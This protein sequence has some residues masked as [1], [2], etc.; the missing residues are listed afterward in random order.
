MAVMVFCLAAAF[1]LP[2]LDCRPMHADE[3][4]LAGKFGTPLETGAYPYDPDEYHGLVLAYLDW[5][6]AHLTGRTSYARLRETTLR[7]APALAGIAGIARR[8][9]PP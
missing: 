2:L 5:I 8:Y 9:R 7:I 1:R 3:A 4:G 6:P